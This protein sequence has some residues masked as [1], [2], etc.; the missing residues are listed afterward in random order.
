M[1]EKVHMRYG[2]WP[3]VTTD[4]ANTKVVRGIL[5]RRVADF[6]PLTGF[7]E[8]VDTE[9]SL[10]CTTKFSRVVLRGPCNELEFAYAGT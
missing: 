9:T 1:L 4:V 7:D 5:G 2:F 3:G 10:V 8:E 6:G